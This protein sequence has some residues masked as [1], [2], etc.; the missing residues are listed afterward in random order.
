MT[1]I[2]A[3]NK[4]E[5]V[6]EAL[7][8]ID[9]KDEIKDL[10]ELKELAELRK[11]L[12]KNEIIEEEKKNNTWVWIL[13]II[14]AVVVCAAIGYLLFK[15]LAPDCIE[16]TEDDF[17]DFDDDFFDDDDLTDW[18]DDDDEIEV[19]PMAASETATEE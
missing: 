8:D 5:D 18:D 7:K 19:T 3:K 15:F 14:G 11:L 17:E 1:I 9:I 13:A 2:D 16:D 10:K 12:K 4:F 6:V